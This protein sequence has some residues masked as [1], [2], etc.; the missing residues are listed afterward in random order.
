MKHQHEAI[1]TDIRIARIASAVVL[2]ILFGASV[3]F[4][5]AIAAKPA[6]SEEA[7][8]V[9]NERAVVVQALAEKIAEEPRALGITD[10]GAVLELFTGGEGDTWTIMLTLPNGKS[11]IVATGEHWLTRPVQTMGRVS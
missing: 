3:L 10:N 7:V 5:S 11:K 4:G 1:K 9:W 6:A 2:G 8:K